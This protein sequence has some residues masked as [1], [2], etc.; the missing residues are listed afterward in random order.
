MRG[1]RHGNVVR[2]LGALAVALC[3][4]A[5]AASTAGGERTQDGHLIVS[6]DGGLAPLALPRDHP[7]P[8]AV[9]LAGGLQTTDG[10]LLPR[11][12]RVELSLPGQGILDTRGLPV[13]RASQLRN[14]TS[15]AALGACRSALVGRGRL[16]AQVH[17]PN[18]PAFA[19]HAELLAFNGRVRGRRAVILHGFASD[20]PTV[21]V[22]P[23]LLR[24]QSG[25]LRTRLVADL[26]PE[27]GPWPHFAHFEVKFFR[28]F[29]FR[30]KERS[31]LSAS[32]PIPK[33]L[34]A[35]FF[36]F[37]KASFTLA[38]GHRVSTSITRS[39]RARAD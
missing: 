6:L 1:R 11:V 5:L 36:S 14:T 33:Q 27:L 12:T 19:V 37:A 39:C 15:G 30:K 32:C 28:R 3:L 35:G 17:V 34:T 10:T 2:S 9:R 29:R 4:V 7:A 31:Y 20:P 23:F 26:P 24:L 8:V 25:L 22:L 38:G 16:D 13:C 18:Q 21:V